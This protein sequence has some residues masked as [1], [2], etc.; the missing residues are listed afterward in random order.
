MIGFVVVV[1]GGLVGNAWATCTACRGL[2][3]LSARL[4]GN[5]FVP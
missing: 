4:G 2:I 1:S 3:Y 5:P